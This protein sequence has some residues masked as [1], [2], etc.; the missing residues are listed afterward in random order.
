ML[1]LSH[2][3]SFKRPSRSQ[4]NKRNENHYPIVFYGRSIPAQAKLAFRVVMMA[5][6]GLKPAQRRRLGY[7]VQAICHAITGDFTR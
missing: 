1:H 3:P 7:I 6:P 4:V 5:G 2:I